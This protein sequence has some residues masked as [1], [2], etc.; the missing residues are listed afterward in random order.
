MKHKSDINIAK[1]C[2]EYLIEAFGSV[3]NASKHTKI[4][5]N[6][7]YSWYNGETVPG[8][9]YLQYLTQLGADPKYLLTGNQGEMKNGRL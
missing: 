1:R 2:Y 5:R 7:I 9:Y 4:S 8:A 3:T 6:T